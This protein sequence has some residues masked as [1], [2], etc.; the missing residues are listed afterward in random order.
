MLTSL[1]TLLIITLQ[2]CRTDARS[3]VHETAA[4]HLPMQWKHLGPADASTQLSLSIALKQ[5]G[6]QE[7]RARLDGISN[8]SHADYGAHVSRENIRR[9]TEVPATG[10]EAV[11]AWLEENGVTNH[12]AEDAWVRFNATVGQIDALL[13]CNMSRYRHAGSSDVLY[14]AK[15]YSLPEELL[16]SVDYVYPVTQFISAS[17]KA[18]R[19]ASVSAVQERSKLSTPMS[20]SGKSPKLYSRK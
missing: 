15:E 20:R 4:A 13:S 9:Y 3:V 14:R 19:S 6:L 11:T 16:G 1:S 8:P 17:K 18:R 2:A 10:L 12:A 5:P 7:L